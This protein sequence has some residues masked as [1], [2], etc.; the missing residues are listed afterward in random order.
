MHAQSIAFRLCFLLLLLLFG[1]GENLGRH[2]LIGT[3]NPF[4]KPDFAVTDLFLRNAFDASI[5]QLFLLG[6]C[7]ETFLP[8]LGHGINYFSCIIVRLLYIIIILV[9]E[10]RTCT[11]RESKNSSNRSTSVFFNKGKKKQKNILVRNFS[12]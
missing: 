12:S 10:G 5:V 3:T 9:V 6:T 4:N 7:F 2:T 1:G 11:T 8:N